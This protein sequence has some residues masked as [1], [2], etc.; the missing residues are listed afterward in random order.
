MHGAGGVVHH[1]RASGVLESSVTGGGAAPSSHKSRKARAVSLSS[2]SSAAVASILDREK[3]LMG[4]PSTILKDLS[5]EKQTK[6]DN[7]NYDILLTSSGKGRTYNILL[8]KKS[9]I[10]W[11]CWLQGCIT[12]NEWMKVISISTW[13]RTYTIIKTPASNTYMWRQ[14]LQLYNYTWHL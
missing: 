2:I 13:N 7:L 10:C 5:W 3:S 14:S 1:R 11:C 8:D 9:V 4:R 12:T 6:T